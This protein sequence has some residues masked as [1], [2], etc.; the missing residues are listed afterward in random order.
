MKRTKNLIGEMINHQRTKKGLTLQEL[1][2]KLETDRHYI[3]KLENGKVNMS[4]DF[5]DKV[6]NSLGI[7]PEDFF[8]TDR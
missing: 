4:L 8:N 5:L 3:W 1:A 2:T 6:I 7:Y